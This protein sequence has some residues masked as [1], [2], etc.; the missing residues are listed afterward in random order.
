MLMGSSWG[1][2]LEDVFELVDHPSINPR[3]IVALSRSYL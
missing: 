1:K 2:V 3:T